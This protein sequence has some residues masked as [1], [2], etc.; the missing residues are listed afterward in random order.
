VKVRQ[1]FLYAFAGIVVFSISCPLRAV[2]DVHYVLLMS[3]YQGE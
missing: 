1:M 3:D 2:F